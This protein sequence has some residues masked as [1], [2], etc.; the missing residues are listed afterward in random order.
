MLKGKFKYNSETLNF[1]R[2]VLGFYEKF[3]RFL[4]F[5]IVNLILATLIYFVFSFFIDSP[6][7]KYLK[8]EN[9]FLISQYESLNKELDE[10]IYVFKDVQQRDDNI[11]RIIFESEPIPSSIRLAGF[12][13]VNRYIKL[14][15]YDNSELVRKTSRKIDVLL[16]QLYIQTKS[17]EEILEFAE[18]KKD[19]LSCIPAIQPIY[20][21]DLKRISSGFGIRTH[22]IL[23]VRRMHYGMD[24]SAIKGTEVYATGNGIISKTKHSRRGSG[25][26]IIIKHGYGYKTKY[27]HLS[28]ILVKPNQIVKRGDIIGLAGNTGFST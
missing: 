15:G 9:E 21:K 3:L 10:I 28:K 25:N 27:A 6:K 22:P 12:G 14:Q 20:N 13:G 24:F 18:N 19:M 7:E 2:I 26:R 11:Y 17:Y 23:K 4:R 5:F 16:S 1:E 8:G